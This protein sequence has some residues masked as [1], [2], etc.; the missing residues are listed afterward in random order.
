MIKRVQTRLSDETYAKLELWAKK[1]GVS[2]SQ[3]SGMAVQA[4][5]DNIIRSVSP[6]DAMTPD[7]WAA[8]FRAMEIQGITMEG[9]KAIGSEEGSDDK[10]TK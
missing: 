4:G 2:M 10:S 8:I 6:V 7:Q 3:L 5:L 9:I 1:L